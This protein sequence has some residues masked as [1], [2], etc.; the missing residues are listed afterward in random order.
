MTINKKELLIKKVIKLYRDT[1]KIRKRLK[2][3]T[4]KQFYK[5]A[6]FYNWKI[7]SDWDNFNR[8][9]NSISKL[10]FK[11]FKMIENELKGYDIKGIDDIALIDIAIAYEKWHLKKY[12]RIYNR[13]Y[14]TMRL[15]NLFD[16]LSSEYKWLPLDYG[17]LNKTLSEL[18]LIDLKD[19]FILI[20]IYNKI[21]NK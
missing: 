12:H 14:K 20:D 4:S 6:S 15:T 8:F 18:K 16:F 17:L 10:S 13:S 21:F 19:T 3:I 9:G 5:L 7:L 2:T 1:F 11:E